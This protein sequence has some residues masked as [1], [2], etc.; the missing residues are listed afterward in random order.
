[1]TSGTKTHWQ[2]VWEAVIRDGRLFEA[3]YGSLA[4]WQQ[5]SAY[6]KQYA[7]GT[8][9]DLGAGKLPFRSALQAVVDQYISLDLTRE[10]PDL[11]LIANG[12]Q[13]PL[14]ADSIDVVFSSQVMEHVPHPWCFMQE[15]TR[16]LK[17][18]GVLILSVPFMFYIHGAPHD[19]YRYT[20]YA[21]RTLVL[22]N[23]LK[24]ECLITIGGLFAFVAQFVQTLL[25]GAT[26]LVPVIR[27]VGWAFNR[28][29]NMVV[30][31][32]DRT[33]GQADR[34][35]QNVLVVARKPS[36]SPGGDQ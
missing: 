36:N 8:V 25:L 23:G 16:V 28:L 33:L 22:E 1:M 32:L 34:F 12:E 2:K 5:Q 24:I 3:T 10:H 6:I 9:L 30:S 19:Y 27:E 15:I 29:I 26:Y 7:H 35:P 14:K 21:V 17:P 18:E 4:L 31:G 11:N 20:P 13:L